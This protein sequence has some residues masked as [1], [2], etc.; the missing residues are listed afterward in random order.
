MGKKA[1]RQKIIDQKIIKGKIYTLVDAI[2]L[3]KSLPPLHFDGSIDISVHLGIDTNKSDQNVRGV[4]RLPYGTG[5]KIRVAVFANGDHATI[6]KEAGADIVGFEDLADSIKTGNINFDILVSTLDAMRIVG[7]LGQILG[8]RG[9]MPNPKMGTVTNDIANAVKNIKN[10][11]I[12]YRADKGGIVHSTIGRISFS[13]AA[14]KENF[15]TF[16]E[17][18]K[19]NKPNNTKGI[20]LRKIVLSSTMG[21]GLII[22]QSSF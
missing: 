3:L 4:I 10:G 6:A 19:K 8:P 18:L 14:I 15:S 5:R 13:V 11:Q 20:Y 21:P 1:K 9:L 12:S 22:E 17:E 2:D 7:Q 16:L